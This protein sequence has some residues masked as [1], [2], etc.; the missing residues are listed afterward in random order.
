MSGNGTTNTKTIDQ[1]AIAA[2][3]ALPLLEYDRQREPQAKNLRCRVAT[4]DRVVEANR[5][6]AEGALQG[7]AVIL[8][9][10]ELWPKPVNGAEVL[11]EVAES[12]TRYVGLPDGAADLLA[13][14]C[15]HTHLFDAF[16][17]SPRLNI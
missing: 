5:A 3:A 12:F 10:V 13:L 1:E 14:W 17:C 11:R 2:L 4:L 16:I 8:P 15:P 9:D 7:S 6:Q